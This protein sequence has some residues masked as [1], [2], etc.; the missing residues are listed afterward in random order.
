MNRPSTPN[1]GPPSYYEDTSPNDVPLN[2]S[3]NLSSM[4][5]LTTVDSEGHP[6]VH[7]SFSLLRHPSIVLA[8]EDG[9]CQPSRPRGGYDMLFV[10]T[11]SRTH[12]T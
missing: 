7:S 5:L 12:I 8:R 11:H 9:H 2:A 10:Y 1:R 6:Y 3:N 4:R